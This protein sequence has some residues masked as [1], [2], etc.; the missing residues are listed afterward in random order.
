MATGCS[1]AGPTESAGV[2]PEELSGCGFT[3]KQNIYEL[4]NDRIRE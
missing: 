3:I 1:G 4:G 2:S